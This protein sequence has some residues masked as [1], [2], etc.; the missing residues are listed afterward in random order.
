MKSLSLEKMEGIEGG[1]VTACDV[2]G[3]LWSGGI[4]M[5]VGASFGGPV[6][7]LVGFGLGLVATHVC[8]QQ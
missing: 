3:G 2:V 6:G 7:F 8:S 5:V 1:K 4:G